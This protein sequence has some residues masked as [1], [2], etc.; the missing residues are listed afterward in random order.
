MKCSECPLGAFAIYSPTFLK[1][2]STLCE[3]RRDVL[4]VRAQQLIL[5]SGEA[6]EFVYTLYSGWAYRFIQFPDGRK[7]IS[8]FL[9]PGD[10][11][12]LES[13]FPSE[14][15]QFS[16]RALT[17]VVLCVFETR[18]MQEILLATQEQRRVV[19]ATAFSYMAETERRMATIGRRRAIGRIARLALDLDARLRLRGL[20][21][22][23]GVEFPL[24]LDHLA[25]ALGLTQAHVSRTMIRLKQRK[26]LETRRNHMRILDRRA[27]EIVADEE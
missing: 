24:K 8:G 26:L 23:D 13:L 14:N 21:N 2:P 4:N 3:A 9:I 27:L 6:P 19:A 15:L 25:N 5:R 11:I 10:T 22:D 12:A 7:Q 1:S 20:V 18:F 16:V 17:D